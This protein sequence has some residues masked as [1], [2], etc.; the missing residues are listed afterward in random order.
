MR[1]I[2]SGGWGGGGG[3]QIRSWPAC[4]STDRP[5]SISSCNSLLQPLSSTR[6]LLSKSLRQV[7]WLYFPAPTA[8]IPRSNT[9][10]GTSARPVQQ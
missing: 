9:R 2:T 8:Q 4:G 7:D 10:Q 5:Q 3:L 1:P 6:R